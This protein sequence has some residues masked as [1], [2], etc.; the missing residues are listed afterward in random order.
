VSPLNGALGNL[1]TL[2]SQCSRTGLICFVPAGLAEKSPRPENTSWHGGLPVGVSCRDP[3]RGHRGTE[4]TETDPERCRAEALSRLRASRRYVKGESRSL[5]VP[6]CATFFSARVLALERRML[7]T[8]VSPPQRTAF[9]LAWRSAPGRRALGTPVARWAKL[10]RPS[11]L[12]RSASC[13]NSLIRF[14]ALKGAATKSVPKSG[15]S[16]RRSWWIRQTCPKVQ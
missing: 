11:G 6:A 13:G 1:V 9:F 7:R 4:V 10:R 12:K 8:P 14:A 5:C 15:F 3:R 16:D 2:A